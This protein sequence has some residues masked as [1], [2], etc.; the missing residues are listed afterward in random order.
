MPGRASEV[1]EAEA[2]CFA[3]SRAFLR[4]T[5]GSPFSITRSLMVRLR[6][7]GTVEASEMEKDILMERGLDGWMICFTD[8]V[9]GQNW[10]LG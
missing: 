7:A 4:M 2:P 1:A 6:R 3:S 9:M 5:R 8:N 10:P